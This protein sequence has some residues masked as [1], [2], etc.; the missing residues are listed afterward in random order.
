MRRKN[1]LDIRL[2]IIGGLALLVM[3]GWVSIEIFAGLTD[4]RIAFQVEDELSPLDPRLNIEILDRINDK[5]SYMI[6]FQ[7]DGEFLVNGQ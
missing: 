4:N 3:I 6:T 2:I 7:E 5:R 1:V